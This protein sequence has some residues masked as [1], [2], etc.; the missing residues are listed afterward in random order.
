MA[1]QVA[2]SHQS[3]F[4]LVR[5]LAGGRIERR[6]SAGECAWLSASMMDGGFWHQEAEE[7]EPEKLQFLDI[8]WRSLSL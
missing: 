8:L 4:G 7:L 1:L 5:L 3:A 2:P 6:E